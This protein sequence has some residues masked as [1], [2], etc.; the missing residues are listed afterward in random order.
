MN[1]PFPMA[2]LN[3][4]RVRKIVGSKDFTFETKTRD[5][6]RHGFPDMAKPSMKAQDGPMPYTWQMPWS[7]RWRAGMFFRKY[8]IFDFQ[9]GAEVWNRIPLV[10]KYRLAIGIIQLDIHGVSSQLIFGRPWRIG[11]FA[12]TCLIAREGTQKSLQTKFVAC[13]YLH[14]QA[15][16]GICPK[17][18]WRQK[19]W[20]VNSTNESWVVLVFVPVF[21]G[22]VLEPTAPAS[23]AVWLK[24]R[25][26]S[27]WQGEPSNAAWSLGMTFLGVTVSNFHPSQVC[28]F[29]LLIQLIQIAIHAGSWPVPSGYLT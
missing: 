12:L 23:P 25:C 3:N 8:P 28:L 22:E 16:C 5:Q 13:W 18:I 15:S 17:K 2:M 19:L 21:L 14:S 9:H 6:R 4:Q 29:V 24:C 7:R 26:A 20:K 27:P 11:C 10:K 1:G